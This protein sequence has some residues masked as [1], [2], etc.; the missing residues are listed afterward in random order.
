MNIVTKGNALSGATFS[1]CMQYR[2]SLWRWLATDY[3][4]FK[5]TADMAKVEQPEP[6]PRKSIA[7]VACNPSTADE[8]ADDPTVTRCINRS[9]EMG[10]D[11]F[12]MLN[13]FAIRATDPKD[14]KRAI[15]PVGLENDEFIRH[16]V[17]Q[18]EMVVCA[19]GAH[20][21]HKDRGAKVLELL[22]DV[23][24]YALK[25]TKSGHPQH[26]LYV[27]NAARPFLWRAKS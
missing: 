15:E 27:A 16:T 19:W 5:S 13:I 2:Y 20:G 4:I 25:I 10:F 18:C 23:D 21:K 26:P 9:R 7:Y 11:R 6:R 24:L 8:L 3:T 14:M 22:K 12:F 1:P 17:A